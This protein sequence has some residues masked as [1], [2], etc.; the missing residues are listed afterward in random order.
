MFK[1]WDIKIVSIIFIRSSDIQYYNLNILS[2][3]V[4][5]YK[6]IGSIEDI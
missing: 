2:S 6:S 4:D 5:R 1:K 3:I